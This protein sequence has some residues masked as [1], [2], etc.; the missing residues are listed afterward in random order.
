[1]SKLSDHTLGKMNWFNEPKTWNVKENTLTMFPNPK[2][3]FWCKTHYGYSFDNGSFYYDT[4]NGEFEV[5]VKITGKYKTKYDQMGVMIRINEKTWIKAGIE[6][7]NGQM[8]VSAVVT[9]DHS[10]W[11]MIKLDSNP[12]SIWIKAVRR[13]NAI[14]IFYSLDNE[15]YQMMRLAYFPENK[16]CL[17]GLMAASP[18]GDGF[19][20]TF[21]EFTLKELY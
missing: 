10:D 18:K 12:E 4:C 15:S 8:N 2:S 11:S 21:E 17:V 9:H 1:M 5:T 16:A 19:K 14:E 20:A 3:D 7:V 6:Y 13:S